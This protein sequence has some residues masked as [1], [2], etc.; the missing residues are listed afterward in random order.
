ME[1]KDFQEKV[2]EIKESVNPEKK[3]YIQRIPPQTKKRFMKLAEEEFENDYG[4]TLKHL[5]DLRDGMYPTG[6]EEIEAKI[7]LLADKISE[8]HEKIIK[9]EH[10]PEK[11]IKTLSGKKIGGNQH[12]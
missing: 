1:N 10:K 11:E 2:K 12:E 4:F 9:L 5:I 7:N 8:L 3:L 6:H